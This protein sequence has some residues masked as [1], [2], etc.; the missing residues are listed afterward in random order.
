MIS[1]IAPSSSTI[2]FYIDGILFN[3]CLFFVILVYNSTFYWRKAAPIV[4]ATIIR[5]QGI[6]KGATLSLSVDESGSLG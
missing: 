4:M 1:Y 5:A 2:C 6:S 3:L